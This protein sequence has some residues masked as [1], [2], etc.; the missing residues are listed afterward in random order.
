MDYQALRKEIDTGP[1][2]GELSGKSDNDV[3]AILNN[4]RYTTAQLVP[5]SKIQP[6]L[7][8]EN[9]WWSIVDA[10]SDPTHADRQYIARRTVDY[11][12]SAR[13]E[14]IDLSLPLVQQMVGGMV[15]TG[16]LTQAQLDAII[17]MGQRLASRAEMLGWP[18]IT[19]NDVNIA[20]AI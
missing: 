1:L 9:A 17:A 20:R 14:N 18:L 7:M 11:F 13:V 4:P 6:Y 2:A 12:N 19:Y 10:A 5:L 15:T 3:A 8:A 16:L